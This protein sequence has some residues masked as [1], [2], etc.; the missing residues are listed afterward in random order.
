[1]ADPAGAAHPSG[2]PPSPGPDGAGIGSRLPALGPHGEGWVALQMGLLGLCFVA[3]LVGPALA[4]G[5]R[6]AAVT[7][8]VAL[9]AAGGLLLLLG[10]L[11]LRENLT[12]FPRPRAAGH[13]VESG[14]YGLVRHP[15][16]TGVVSGA[17][18]WALV[19]ASPAALGAAG[20][21]LAFFDLKARREEAWLLAAY[22]GYAAYRRR[23]RKLVPF[24][25]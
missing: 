18:G 12:P 24:V 5:W 11:G 17:V 22:P 25:Y 23:V 19:T 6:A 21:L 10:S 3:G 8:G 9:I 7:A 2:A 13:L 20:L 14:V 16:Y 4:G 1:M 15:I